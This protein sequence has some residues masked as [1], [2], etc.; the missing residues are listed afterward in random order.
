MII[1][2]FENGM[3]SKTKMIVRMSVK[4]R[5]DMRVKMRSAN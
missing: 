5:A 4:M 1:D 3:F 2:A